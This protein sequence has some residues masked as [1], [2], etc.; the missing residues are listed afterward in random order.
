MERILH[1][2]CMYRQRESWAKVSIRSIL[3]RGNSLF[4]LLTF[5]FCLPRLEGPLHVPPPW[6][7]RMFGEHAG[8]GRLWWCCF[9]ARSLT[10]GYGACTSRHVGRSTLPCQHH[11]MWFIKNEKR[12]MLFVLPHVHRALQCVAWNLRCMPAWAGLGWAGGRSPL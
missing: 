5:S 7:P 4:F 6:V 11:V 1:S 10:N 3:A 12:K 2:T 8:A 9:W